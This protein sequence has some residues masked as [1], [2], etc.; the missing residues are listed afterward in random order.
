MKYSIASLLLAGAL[1]VSA[2]PSA[3]CGQGPGLESGPQTIN[4]NGQD[5]EFIVRVPEGYDNNNPYRL[6]LGI[7][8]W[9]GNMD[10]V[11]YGLTVEEGVWNYYGLE[12]L[13]DETAIFVAP[14]GIDGNWY[15]EGDS[16][17]A[18]LNEVNR[19]VEES[20]CVD[21]DLRFAIGFSWGASMS[22]ALACGVG[23]Y[24]LR[25]ATAIG[26][27]GPFECKLANAAIE[28]RH[29]L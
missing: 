5:R 24:P 29:K 22:V 11:A 3:G 10:D 28:M 19:L 26:A 6:V 20:L 16:D 4:V 14:N 2:A 7:H 21:T 17:Y 25:A 8:W 27:A 18:F 13:A 23:E 15:N 12:R 9:G 1:G